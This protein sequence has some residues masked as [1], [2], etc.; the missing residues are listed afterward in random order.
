MLCAVMAT[1]RI[2]VLNTA[3]GESH[4]DNLPFDLRHLRWPIKY[5]LP[6]KA[7][8]AQKEAAL[9]A[10]VSS[11]AGALKLILE[12]HPRFA[13]P[14]NAND[15]HSR[16]PLKK[17][18]AVFC[19]DGSE[20]I[21]EAPFNWKSEVIKIADEGRAYMRL[22]PLKSQ[23]P[24]KTALE[25]RLLASKGALRPMGTDLSGWNM[26]RNGYGAVVYEPPVD[27]KMYH[28]TQ[29]FLSRELWGIDAFAVNATHC[30]NFTQGK[31]G[32]YIAS[33]YVERMFTETLSNYLEFARQHLQLPV[34]VQL[35]AGLTGIKGYP[36]A[37]EQGMPGRILTN[38]VQWTG[39]IPSYEIPPHEI[40]RPFFDYMWAECGLVRPDRFHEELARQ[41]GQLS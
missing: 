41:F 23:P 17:D 34:P 24:L 21:P 30:K 20:L 40:L 16:Q 2:A 12:A 3:F 1:I 37:I 22:Y 4:T 10:L 18:P 14:A 15:F 36:I 6:P 28:L 8:A 25:A 26:E 9:E 7:D 32:G 11:L 13:V 38:H 33:T 19:E 27:R 29:L 31:S 35:E 5:H 39:T